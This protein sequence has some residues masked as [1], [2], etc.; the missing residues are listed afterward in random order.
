VMTQ[1][2]SLHKEPFPHM[3]IENFYDPDELKLIWEELTFLTKPK[4]LVEAKH[5]GG[6]VDATNSHALCLDEIY[7]DYSGDDDDGPNFRNLSNI[8]TLNRKLFNDEI[9]TEFAKTHDSC[10]LIKYCNSDLTKVRYY[11]DGEYYKP[12][13]DFSMNFLGLY[14]THKEPKKFTGGD[15]I[16]P[17]YNSQL[18]CDNNSMILMPGW[19][20]HGVTKVSIKESD[21]YDGWGR[22]CISSFIKVTPN[23]L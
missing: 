12:H 2:K 4:K 3:I 16:F 18:T 23:A 10:R 1:I 14:Y 19:V 13:T 7:Q 8:L 5:F 22:Y 17:Y 9:L 20:E 21:Y 6:I 15:L 11:H